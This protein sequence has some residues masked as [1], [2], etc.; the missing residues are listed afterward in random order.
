MSRRLIIE[1]DDK[2]IRHYDL[3]P[4]LNRGTLLLN[5]SDM[6]SF[7]D[8]DEHDTELTERVWGL[9]QKI[10]LKARGLLEMIPDMSYEE[11]LMHYENIVSEG[12]QR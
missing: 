7:P 3:Y 9:A 10:V 6:A 12:D 11:A 4:S 5:R 2:P 8:A 1:V